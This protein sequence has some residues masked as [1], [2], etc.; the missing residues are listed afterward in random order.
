[1]VNPI[2]TILLYLK[3]LQA[4]VI[5]KKVPKHAGL[6]VLLCFYFVLLLLLLFCLLLSCFVSILPSVYCWLHRRL[7][8]QNLIDVSSV[9]GALVESCLIWWFLQPFWLS[10]SLHNVAFTHAMSKFTVTL[11]TQGLA[12]GLPLTSNTVN[13][14]NKLNIPL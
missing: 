2:Q 5:K 6:T 14:R 10:S 1:M 9:I 12:K 8:L 7:C 11:V 3:L 13:Q 4:T